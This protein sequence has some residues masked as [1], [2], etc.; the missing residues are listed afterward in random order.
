MKTNGN[1]DSSG[2]CVT[3][4]SKH[5]KITGLQRSQSE[6]SFNLDYNRVDER[7]Y[8]KLGRNGYT[9]AELEN[10]VKHL[11]LNGINGNG[12]LPLYLDLESGDG[13][14]EKTFA[15][16]R[17]VLD[18]SSLQEK[19]ILSRKGSVRGLKNRVRAG[20]NTFMREA[21]DNTR[22]I[23]EQEIGKIVI[24]TTS[25]TVV[26]QTHERCKI[27]KK[28]LQNH[29]VRYE[30]KDLFMN[31]ENQKELMERLGSN[32]ISLPQVFA[33][34]NLL[35]SEDE[36]E[37]LNE[38]GE[39]KKILEHFEKINV[40]SHCEKCGGYR[41]IPCIHCHGSKK[42]LKRNFF[43]EEFYSLRCMQCDENGLQRCD[44]CLDQQE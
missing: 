6:A 41:Y 5:K 39:L 9:D 19:Q 35:G 31:S 24:Y 13:S 37:K 15:G 42:S 14:S 23:R 11:S 26:R 25:M 32:E 10:H 4:L 17:N 20:I 44:M 1:L 22:K 29:M 3:P 12:T 43:T 30:E 21:P 40:R 28:I 36:L 7:K 34:G 18:P 16:R 27:V 38:I 33:D 8:C 2:V